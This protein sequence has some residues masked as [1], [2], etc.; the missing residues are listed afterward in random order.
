MEPI[1]FVEV[2][3]QG[4]PR[5]FQELPDGRRVRRARPL[6]EV[7]AQHGGYEANVDVHDLPGF[8]S[9]SVSLQHLR[10]ED[11]DQILVILGYHYNDPS[12][13]GKHDPDADIPP[14]AHDEPGEHGLAKRPEDEGRGAHGRAHKPE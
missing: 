6:R 2:L 13:V 1:G 14:H 7:L 3:H 4:D 9:V 12:M 8:D 5:E 11:P 10:G